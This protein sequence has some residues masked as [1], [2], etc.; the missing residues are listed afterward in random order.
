MRHRNR[1]S[2]SAVVA[3]TV[4]T[5]AGCGD[6]GREDAAAADSLDRD[7]QLAPVDSG[8]ALDDQPASEPPAPAATTP[9]RP[10]SRPASRPGTPTR[11]PAAPAPRAETP[12][13]PATRTVAAGTEIETAAGQMI[14]SRQNKA[15][16]TFTATIG[17]DVKDRQGRVVI[18]AGSTVTYS[19]VEIAPAEN[20]GQKDGKLVLR[21]VSVEVNGRTYDVSGTVTY[22][23]HTLKGRGVTAGD[24]AKVGAGAAV[25]AIAG[26]VLGGGKTGT[27]VGGVV[28]AA[29]GTAV[30]V[31]TADR[32]VV[33]PAGGKITMVLDAPLTV[34][35]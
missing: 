7:L 25:G 29:A 22:A 23:E 15:G 30:A 6:R 9:A 18:P 16:E 1:F 32:D 3:F 8:A 4:L 31:E 12:A 2:R 26:K 21:P 5:L 28:G 10:A 27:I 20:K 33:V 24:A 34:S 13:A 11:E 14:T 35:R 17:A 19:I